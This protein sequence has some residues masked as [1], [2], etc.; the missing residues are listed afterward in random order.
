MYNY[1]TPARKTLYNAEFSAMLR[2][3]FRTHNQDFDYPKILLSG[4][5]PLLSDLGEAA[6]GPQPQPQAERRGGGESRSYDPEREWGE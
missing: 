4:R 2:N 1:T 6:A 3:L 5:C